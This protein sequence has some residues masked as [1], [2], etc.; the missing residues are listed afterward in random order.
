MPQ[1]LAIVHNHSGMSSM[2]VR[3]TDKF[4]VMGMLQGP[5]L[6]NSMPAKNASD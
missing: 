6:Q 4:H 1:G 5:I 2:V 3:D